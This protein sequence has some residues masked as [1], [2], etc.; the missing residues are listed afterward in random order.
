MSGFWKKKFIRIYI[1]FSPHFLS[2]F[3][4]DGH[5]HLLVG[6]VVKPHPPIENL[7]IH[8]KIARGGIHLDHFQLPFTHH[9]E[10]IANTYMQN[11]HLLFN[12]PHKW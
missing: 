2:F 8:I 5:G 7:N 12:N 1:T 6:M 4:M 10:H 9:H 11:G 3:K